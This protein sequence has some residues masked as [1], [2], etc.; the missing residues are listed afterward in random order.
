M[1]QIPSQDNDVM[2][3]IARCRDC[4]INLCHNNYNNCVKIKK[5]SKI[6]QSDLK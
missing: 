3:K 5:T 2:E 6:N 4:D 1:K